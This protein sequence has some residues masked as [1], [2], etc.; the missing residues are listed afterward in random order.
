M[1]TPG[2]SQ[3]AKE[4]DDTLVDLHI[5]SE[6]ALLK[7]LNLDGSEEDSDVLDSPLDDL[8]AVVLGEESLRRDEQ[9]MDGFEEEIRDDN[10][11]ENLSIS[12]VSLDAVRDYLKQIGRVSLLKVEQEIDLAKRIEV[13]LFAKYLRET[14]DKKLT[15][16]Q[17]REYEILEADGVASRNH[18]LEANFRLVVSIAKRYTQRG[19][20]FLDLIQEGNLGLVRAV[21]KFDYV[22]GFKFST[23]ATWWVRQA[24][25][26]AMADQSRTIR[27]PVHMV[28]ILNKLS[29]ESRRFILQHGKE[30]SNAELAE[31]ME[32]TEKRVQEVKKYGHEPISL[33]TPLGDDGGSEFGDLIEDPDSITPEDRSSHEA[34]KVEIDKILNTLNPREAMVI[35][36]RFGLQD[37]EPKSLDEIGKQLGVTR[38]RIRQIESKALAKLNHPSRARALRDFR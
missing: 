36:M 26:R 37:Q 35:A 7:E 4:L 15:S 29:R 21:E 23:Y 28:E 10:S 14:Q 31:L 13:G 11:E 6:D 3:E 20:S 27:I 2:A 12:P 19:M 5:A 33:H 30:P 38:E 25:T 1:F 34:L 8:E 18:L 9:D 16:E 22:R 32:I 17:K 24:I